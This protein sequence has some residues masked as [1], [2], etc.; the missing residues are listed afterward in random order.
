MISPMAFTLLSATK[1]IRA[2][3]FNDHWAVW[4]TA[5]GDY[6]IG[7]YIALYDDGHIDRITLH[8]DGTQSIFRLKD[9]QDG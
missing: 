3:R 1:T 6:T 9:R 5:N 7:T 4:L 8:E 2:S